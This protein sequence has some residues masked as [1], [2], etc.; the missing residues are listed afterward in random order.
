MTDFLDPPPGD[1]RLSWA[2]KRRRVA[3]LGQNWARFVR[4]GRC[5]TCET[6]LIDDRCPDCKN[7]WTLVG[8]KLTCTS[9]LHL[10]S[11]Y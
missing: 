6:R 2:E 5:P 7:R 4:I 3:I 11:C 8:D 1:P 10:H 9:D